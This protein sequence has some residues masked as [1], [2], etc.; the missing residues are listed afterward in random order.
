LF[1][2]KEGMV[3]ASKQIKFEERPG[4]TEEIIVELYVNLALKD[5]ER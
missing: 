4:K 2:A 5:I 1:I 3:K